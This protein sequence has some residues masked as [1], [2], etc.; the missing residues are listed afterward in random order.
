M[1]ESLA[2]AAD[3]AELWPQVAGRATGMLTGHF[4]SYCLFDSIPAYRRPQ[5]PRPLAGR[6]R[7]GA[8]RPRG[9][10]GHRR[11]AARPRDRGPH[12]GRLRVHLLARHPA[13]LRAERRAL[14]RR[15][16]RR[17]RA[18]ADRGRLRRDARGR[19]PGAALP[20]DPQLLLGQ[21]RAGPGDAAAPAGGPRPLRRRRAL[22][23]DLRR[24]AAH[25][26][27]HPLDARPHP[28]R[29][30]APRVGR[31]EADPRHRPALRPRR[32][33]HARA[34]HG[35]RPQ[36]DRPRAA[37]AHQPAGRPR[38]AGRRRP[39]APGRRGLHGHGQGRHGHLRRRRRHRRT[40]RPSP[41]R[42]LA[43]SFR[44]P[45]ARRTR[46]SRGPRGPRRTA[47]PP[48]PARWASRSRPDRVC[49]AAGP[50]GG[51]RSR[52]SGRRR[53]P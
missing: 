21:P 17:H 38:P 41:P 9:A 39:P 2:A 40:P 8:A 19:G 7:G 29:A 15:R 48:R 37:A 16:G 51:T 10:P 1:A 11:V 18:H 35:R 43:S 45:A 27:A 24:L 31:E 26:H 6:V 34:R 13:R 47:R 25:V 42:R 5:A 28:G 44:T 22:R 49:Q 14:H 32:P 50:P 53:R 3:G 4:S 20:A 46:R 33:G 23:G 52:H 12:E 30:A 36:R